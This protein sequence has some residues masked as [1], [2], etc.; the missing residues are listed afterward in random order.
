VPVYQIKIVP[1][2]TWLTPFHA[3][4]LFGHI[5]WFIRYYQDKDALKTFL[6]PFRNDKPSWLISDAFPGD[7]LPFPL[8]SPSAM[9]KFMEPRKKEYA[10]LKDF[11]KLKYITAKLFDQFRLGD[12]KFLEDVYTKFKADKLAE[13]EGYGVS[14]KLKTAVSLHNSIDRLTSTTPDSGGLYS[15]KEHYVGE[16]KHLS[17]YIASDDPNEV[18][19]VIGYL[20]GVGE[21]GFGAKKSIGKG[22]FNVCENPKEVKWKKYEPGQKFVTLA[23]FVPRVGDIDL[24]E[25]RYNLRLKKGKL[26]E[27]F[28]T[29]NTPFAKRPIAMI[30]PGSLLKPDG[31]HSH[32]GRLITSEDDLVPG[33]DHSDEVPA[34]DI[35]HYAYAFPVGVTSNNA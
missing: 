19:K 6:D 8:V 20:K 16:K 22:A 2:S 29:G 18:T 1:T 5:A 21:I 7:L 27:S 12:E 26:G 30:E 24:S 23:P 10:S 17:I 31:D 3:D 13:K 4:T 25:S 34:N 28:S 35:V 32:F 15:L 33:L 11:K 14:P 9:A